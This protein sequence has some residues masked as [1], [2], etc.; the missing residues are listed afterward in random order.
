MASVM[1]I[2]SALAFATHSFFQDNGFLSMEVP[3]M[4]TTDG[5]GC[6][7]KFRVTTLSGKE[8]EKG[9]PKI[10][11]DTEGVRLEV[12]KG[13][14]KEKNNL[15]QQLQRSDSNK[16]ALFIAE[17]DLLKTNQLLAQLEEKEKLRLETLKKASKANVP[18]DF[19]SQHTYLTVSGVLHL[20]SYAC[21]LGN[22]YSFGPRFR[23]DRKGTAKQVAEMWA[24]EAEMAFS[25]L[26]V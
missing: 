26:E 24:V 2:R 22:V 8:V 15:I 11:D 1:R 10:T 4:T 20:E 14:I 16:E 6:S 19:F 3:I 7:A 18:E 13:A 9:K 23:A 17:Q 5:E 12:V 21:S 25:E